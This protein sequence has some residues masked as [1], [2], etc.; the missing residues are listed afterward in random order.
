MSN[1]EA[2]EHGLKFYTTVGL[3]F[4]ISQI[5]ESKVQVPLQFDLP[6]GLCERHHSTANRNEVFEIIL[7]RHRGTNRHDGERK[8]ERRS[9]QHRA[10]PSQVQVS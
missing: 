4:Q 7:Q 9:P 1:I 10:V 6:L 5:L 3:G 2:L 8:E